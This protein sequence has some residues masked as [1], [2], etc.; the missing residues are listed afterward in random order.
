M[1]TWVGREAWQ[2]V[3]RRWHARIRGATPPVL[4]RAENL[5][6]LLRKIIRKILQV[7]E[8]RISRHTGEGGLVAA[9]ARSAM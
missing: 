3:D 2:G 9:L 5:V 1:P 7:G 8:A 4:V 6:E